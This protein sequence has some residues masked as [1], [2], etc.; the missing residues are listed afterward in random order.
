MQAAVAQRVIFAEWVIA[1]P[2]PE[3]RTVKHAVPIHI[4]AQLPLATAV[5]SLITVAGTIVAMQLRA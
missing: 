4:Y 1:H 3:S 5:A 2:R